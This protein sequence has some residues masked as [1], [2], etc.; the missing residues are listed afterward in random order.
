MHEAP[1]DRSGWSLPPLPAVLLS[2]VSVQ[3]GA[4]LAKGLFPALGAAGTAGVRIALAALVLLV[5]FRPPL[6]RFTR[7]QWAAV[8]PYGLALG[9]MNLSY[10]LA[11]ARIPLGLGVT[12]EF[13]G[14]LVVA[15]AGS[16]RLLDFLWVL[17]AAVGIV[18][19]TPWSGGPGALDMIGVLLALFA[20]ACWAAY[21]VLGGRLSRL[22]PEGQGVA[23]GMVFA[24]LVVLPVSL[25]DGVAAKLTPALLAAG[26]GVALLSSALPYTLEMMALRVLPS[27][28]FGILMSL[29]PAVATLMGFLFLHER[30][31]PVQWLAVAL[32][33]AASAGSTLT[34]RRVPPPIEA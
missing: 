28:T 15:V 9:A 17:V 2:I 18:L 8:I 12:L 1:V 5:A 24:T 30:L 16:R 23:T 33:S 10:Y 19:I 3:G 14:P 31:S 13:V 4:A 27:R 7:A 22:L 21:I 26:L 11:I 6:A 32:V 34:A 29:E 25:A 20:G